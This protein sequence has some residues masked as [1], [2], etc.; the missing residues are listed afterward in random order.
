MTNA[1]E[2]HRVDSRLH[3]QQKQLPYTCAN[4]LCNREALPTYYDNMLYL[5]QEYYERD[6]V[7]E[8]D[9]NCFTEII[10]GGQRVL[11]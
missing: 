8:E 3:L 9:M 1:E 7:A 2:E 10:R 4:V 6:Q 11:S 5:Q